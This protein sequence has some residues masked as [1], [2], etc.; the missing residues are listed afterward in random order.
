MNQDCAILGAGMTGLAAGWASG[1]QVY[2]AAKEPGGICSSY[3][4]RPNS[5]EALARR[6]ED[7]EAYRF[8]I[9]GGHW[10][11]GGDPAVLKF[12]RTLTSVKSY[13]RSSAVYFPR[14]NL[15]V[16]YP[17][18]NHLRSLDRA[19]AD[20]ALHEMINPPKEIQKTMAGWLEQNFGPTL[21]ELFFGP[22]H[23]LYTAG[24]WKEIAPQD[25]Y[26]SPV[27]I[28]HAIAGAA[29]ETK[30]VGY[31]VAFVYPRE[32]LNTLAQRLTD[33]NQ[34][35]FGKRVVKIELDRKEINFDDGSSKNY[36]TLISTL[37][38][39]KMMEIC[40]LRVD[41]EPDPY[42]SVLVLNIGA[43]KGPQC[44]G[45][46]WLYI[47]QSKS[48]FHRVGFYSNV[49]SSFLPKSSRE[50]NNLVSIYVERA[51]AN[52]LRPEETTIENYG[53]AVVAELQSWGFIE[54]AE[55]VHPTWIDVAYTWSRPGSNWRDKALKILEENDIYMIGRYGR[56]IFQGIADSIKDGLS[57]GTA[58][59]TGSTNLS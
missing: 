55:V 11:F 12:I 8:E 35:H 41:E 22:F 49:D 48:R 32:G 44:P 56:W 17:I 36:K 20:K 6:P 4:V 24:L 54:G 40:G 38:L 30:P 13:S 31:N 2:E 23:K 21:T 16:P 37:P 51:Y 43:K 1:L 25:P 39:N 50:M 33:K 52:G 27:N 47:P 14:N 15:Y 10:I 45:E 5:K 9:G 3:Y 28:A 57:V 53:Q 58:F 46:H 19:T 29:D 18:Q 26:K 34:I 7:G 59:K 42:T